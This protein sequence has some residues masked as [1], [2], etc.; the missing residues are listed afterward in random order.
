MSIPMK[1]VASL[2]GRHLRPLFSAA[3]L[4]CFYKSLSSWMFILFLLCFIPT[5]I[6][7]DQVGRA[8]DLVLVVA[9]RRSKVAR[10]RGEKSMRLRRLRRREKRE[11]ERESKV[12]GGQ[13]QWLAGQRGGASDA[14][15]GVGQDQLLRCRSTQNF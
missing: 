13:R 10:D 4:Y 5:L 15:G 9:M 14:H 12:C 2:G 11:A 6:A 7:E 8:L 3:T 1:V